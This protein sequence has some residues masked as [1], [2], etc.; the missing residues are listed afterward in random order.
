MSRPFRVQEVR[1]GSTFGQT[2]SGDGY[3]RE[4]YPS[5]V[6]HT[7]YRE[8]PYETRSRSYE[9]PLG[10]HYIEPPSTSSSREQKRSGF[11]SSHFKGQS[12]REPRSRSCHP[13]YQGGYGSYRRSRSLTPPRNREV[14]R[15]HHA[16]PISASDA[17][18]Q[19]RPATHP[20]G[21]R[22]L[23]CN[24]GGNGNIGGVQYDDAEEAYVLD[25]KFQR[26]GPEFSI[27]MERR[28]RVTSKR[29]GGRRGWLHTTSSN[30]R[31]INRRGDEG[32]FSYDRD[33]HR[34]SKGTY[35]TEEIRRADHDYANG[36]RKQT[37][38]YYMSSGPRSDR[39][40]SQ[41]W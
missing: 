41:R 8:E 23:F 5:P 28:D 31:S 35:R 20:S 13:S 37:R 19:F 27:N 15:R 6:S 10:S 38:T 33:A 18:T 21:D 22:D 2:Y 11:F 39:R 12:S 17:F 4:R 1:P 9:A 7:R 25:S 16:G 3:D 14:L 36:D 32:T 24:I 30:A 40:L 29:S 26:H 34:D